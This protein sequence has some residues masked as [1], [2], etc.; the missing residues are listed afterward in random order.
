MAHSPGRTSSPYTLRAER[1]ESQTFEHR[2][3]ST[4]H[5]RPTEPI[6]VDIFC[7][8]SSGVTNRFR[9]PDEVNPRRKWTAGSLYRCD[10]V[11]D[12]AGD[13]LPVSLGCGPV[14]A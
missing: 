6:S 9:I 7:Q 14:V 2:Y 10:R 13:G 4:R 8:R 1:G 11:A 5:A 12:G 3:R